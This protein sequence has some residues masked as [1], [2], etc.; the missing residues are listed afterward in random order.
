MSKLIEIG[1]TQGLP[2]RLAIKVGDVLKF[3]ATGARVPSPT[4]VLEIIG[5][6]ISSVVGDDGQVLTPM[7]APNAVLIIGRHP[8]RAMLEVVTGDPWNGGRT[9]KLQ[10]DVEK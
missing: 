8:G 10:V 2:A 6:Y 9:T 4:N 5:F 7:G 1:P 3:R